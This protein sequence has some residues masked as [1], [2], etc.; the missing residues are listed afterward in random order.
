MFNFCSS[1]WTRISI[2]NQGQ[3]SPCL[4]GVLHTKGHYGDL[5][6]QS[7]KEI[8]ESP[9]MM[10]MKN[11]VVDQTFK[12][13]NRRTCSTFSNLERIESL[14]HV[15]TMPKLPTELMLQLDKNCNLKCASCRTE[16]IYSKEIDQQVLTILNRITEDYQDVDYTV[17]LFADGLGDIF[18]S[19]AYLHWF[20][21]ADIPSKFRF[22]L[23]TNGNLILKN[24]DIIERIQPQLSAVTVSLDAST[25][26]TYKAIRG[27]NFEIVLNGIR[28]LVNR[29]ITVN[30][31]FVLQ[32]LNH[33]EI[34]EYI[35]LAQSLGVSSIGVNEM[36]KWG[37]MTNT[38]WADNRIVNNDQI[39]R[40]KISKSL[41]K[42]D[43]VNHESAQHIRRAL[44]IV[45]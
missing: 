1:P 31:E 9:W 24:L 27:G 15:K 21:T 4:C 17:E 38:W 30:T 39:D 20:R 23:T 26:E 42:L 37:H 28:E 7:L 12:Y 41:K 11:S 34:S 5:T 2:N 19:Q 13:C 29:G 36:F 45:N 43:E 32:K 33:L 25:P 10:E 44:N 3:I 22:I 40:K 16:N 35:E 14:D 8:V 18:A 6:K